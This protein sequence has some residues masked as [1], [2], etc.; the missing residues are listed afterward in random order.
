MNHKLMLGAGALLGFAALSVCAGPQK[1][2]A[3]LLIADFEGPSYGDGWKAEGDA[4]GS[5]PAKGSFPKQRKV[6]GFLGKGFVNSYLN[7]DASTGSLTSPE[8]KIERDY[9][10]FLIGGGALEGRTCVNLLVDGA[11]VRSMAGANGEELMPAGW[12]VS[13]LKGRNARIQIIDNSSG[14]WGHITMDQIVQSDVKPE[15]FLENQSRPMTMK[16]GRYLLLPIKNGARKLRLCVKDQAGALV[17]AMN[18]ELADGDFDWQA[19][20]DMEGFAGKTVSVCVDRLLEGSKGLAN[21]SVSNVLPGVLPAKDPVRPQFH[22]TSR[23]GWLNDPNGLVHSGGLWHLYYQHNPYGLE[24]ENM[25]WGHAVSKDLVH[26]TELPAAMRPWTFAKGHAFSGSAVVDKENVAGFGANAM[27]AFLTDTAAGEAI[28]Y[29]NDNG[30]T[31]KYWEGNPVVKHGGRDPKVFWFQ[32]GR[33]WVMAVYDEDKES[34]SIAIYTS[35]NLKE[36]TFQSKNEGFYECP[37]LFP[38]AVD[39]KASDTRWLMYGADNQHL[40]GSF[41]GKSFSPASPE[42]TK[43]NYGNCLYAAQTY[44]STPDGRRIQIGWARASFKGSV[45][46]QAMTVPVELSLRKSAEGVKLFSNPVKELESLRRARQEFPKMKLDSASKAVQGA[47][48][49][50]ADVLAELSL[51]G[52]S[53]VSL[54]VSGATVSYDASA[55]R[56]S[57]CGCSAPLKLSGGKLNLRILAD[58][59]IL[60]IFANDGEV[61]MPVALPKEIQPD[62]SISAGASGEGASL[63]RLTV[64]KMEPAW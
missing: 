11:A 20:V 14:G 17:R 9:V 26:W 25:H 53:S 32:P 63:E 18:V 6:S 22:F 44:N 34:K 2:S 49:E 1:G 62:S 55:G 10:K 48:A 51:G 29:S 7:G 28:A 43:G 56:L 39:G 42:R 21:I 46:N 59:G 3:D 47:S 35:K 12:N 30:R 50:L 27:I 58:R 36:W 19:P 45:F 57:C 16:E 37:E 8:F 24:W 61:Y 64:F 23:F 38:L 41:D 54:K 13:D 33:H 52:A 31:F 4:F 15:A 40:L 5:G 60:E